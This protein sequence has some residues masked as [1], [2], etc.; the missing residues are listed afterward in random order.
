MRRWP[1]ILVRLIIFIALVTVIILLYRRFVGA[2]KAKPERLAAAMKKC[3]H[4]G[5]HI[6]AGEAVIRDDEY[7][8]CEDHAQ[9]GLQQKNDD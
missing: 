1:L 9:L 4:C 2:F 3:A 5:I 7:Y 6:P 8:C